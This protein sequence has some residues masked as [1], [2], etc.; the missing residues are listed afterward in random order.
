MNIT[1]ELLLPFQQLADA[2]W[3]DD[4]EKGQ[5]RSA[6]AN[7]N[8]TYRA[9]VLRQHPDGEFKSI[10]FES[11]ATSL[12]EKMI[13]AA[14]TAQEAR[15]EELYKAIVTLACALDIDLFPDTTGVASANN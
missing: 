15:L 3:T 8:R 12:R 10:P 13:L 5:T 6:L 11:L 7:A 1:P 2:A 14:Y 4:T 9:M